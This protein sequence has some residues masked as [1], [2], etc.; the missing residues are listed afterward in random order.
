MPDS[1]KTNNNNREIPDIQRTIVLIGRPNVGK[2]TLFN[3]LT[4]SR[5]A[6]VTAVPGTTRD[7]KEA[8]VVRDEFT[9]KLVDTGGLGFGHEMAFSKEVEMQIETA[10]NEADLVWMILDAKDGLNPFDEELHRR[11]VRSGKPFLAVINKADNPGRRD[12]LSEFYR[13][14]VE[15]IF[16]ISSHHGTGIGDLL[17]SS[18]RIL[19][20]I[21]AEQLGAAAEEEG[22]HPTKVALVGRPNVGKSSLLNRILG[23]E[24]MIVSP[25]PG[26]TRESVEVPFRAFGKE[27][28]LVDTAGIRRKSKTKEHLEKIGVLQSLGAI[29]RVHVVL[30]V[31]DAAEEIATQDARIASYILERNRAVVLLL[32]K[33]DCIGKSRTKARAVEDDIE[34]K[35]GFLN[36]AARVRTSALVDGPLGGQGLEKVFREIDLAASQFSRKIQTADLNRMIQAAVLR[37]PPPM[38]GRSHTRINYG[39]QV[40]TGPP[41][42]R[43]FTNHPESIPDSYT[44]FFENQLRYHFGFAGT[45]LRI[46]WQ[47][48]DSSRGSG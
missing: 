39:L 43:F 6:L 27:Y 18:S 47:G 38:K 23:D 11:V 12:D 32:N 1:I 2:S 4:R 24:R 26:T 15:D 21:L 14:G 42:F 28:L 45:P 33:W 30:L 41:T 5:K 22:P 36:F 17:E 29:P 31:V 37:F 46:H 19:P 20:A 34:R 16:P 8:E 35:L 44:R 40:A 13:L 3:R 25:I 7:R 9:F 48:K 10:L